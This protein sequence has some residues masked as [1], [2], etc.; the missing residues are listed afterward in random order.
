M[1]TFTFEWQDQAKIN[2]ITPKWV[3]KLILWS[4][5]VAYLPNII[6]CFVGYPLDAVIMQFLVM[7]IGV[8]PIVI[9]SMRAY[10]K[11][12][13]RIP[14]NGAMWM[15]GTNIVITKVIMSQT[16]RRYI[17]VWKSGVPL[18]ESI[19]LNKETGDMIIKSLWHVEAYIRKRNG[20]RG[21]LIATDSLTE[22]LE[23][24][25][26]QEKIDEL[27]KF[28]ETYY[29]NETTIVKEVNKQ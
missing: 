2:K 4:I 19:T 23:V 18:I 21:S 26:P 9:F 14:L 16:F 7:T 20:K 15:E 10:R 22:T 1:N 17:E 3:I 11:Q 28:L 12:D 8:P 13:A 6:W 27:E 25:V 29:N 5:V 24:S